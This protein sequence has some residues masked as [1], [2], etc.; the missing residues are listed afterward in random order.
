[1]AFKKKTNL[2]D[3]LGVEE[4]E[5][6]LAASTAEGSSSGYAD[7]GGDAIEVEIDFDAGGA[8]PYPSGTYHARLESV[9]KTVAKSSGN[10]M[11]VWRFRTLQDKRVFY[12]NTVLTRDAMWKVTET[13]KACGAVGVGQVKLDI[14]KLVGN[15]CRLVIEQQ[16]YEGEARPGIKKVL[17]PTEETFEVSDLA[18]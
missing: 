4:K 18:G 17:S 5:L 3:E 13:A 12:V 10:K 2:A 16:T 8:L 14:A 1:M 6:V 9:E 11:V 7:D 15:V